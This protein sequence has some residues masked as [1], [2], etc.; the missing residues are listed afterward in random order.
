V[1]VTVDGC[2]TVLLDAGV[3][4]GFVS[5]CLVGGGAGVDRLLGCLLV[6]LPANTISSRMMQD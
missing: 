1:V 2:T 6:N 3:N 5:G 4:S